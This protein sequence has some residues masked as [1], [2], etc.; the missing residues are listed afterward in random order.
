[1]RRSSLYFIVGVIL[2]FIATSGV[3][4]AQSFSSPSVFHDRGEMKWRVD[5]AMWLD[6]SGELKPIA[7]WPQGVYDSENILY[8]YFMILCESYTDSNGVV[9]PKFQNNNPSLGDLVLRGEPWGLYQTRRYDNPIVI[10]N[11]ANDGYDYEGA[12]DPDIPADIVTVLRLK[13]APGFW[14]TQTTYSFVNPNHDDYVI[15]HV[16]IEYTRN[17]DFRDDDPDIPPQDLL[18]VYFGISYHLQPAWSGTKEIIGHRWGEDAYDDWVDWEL[19]DPLIPSGLDADRPDMVLAYGWDGNE[20][21]VSSL[22]S[23]GGYFDDTGDPSFQHDQ[24]GQFLSYQY[25]GYT[26]LH[27]DESPD[28]PTNDE[29]QPHSMAIAG[30]Y[31][32]WGDNYSG[33]QGYDFIAAGEWQH[34]PDEEGN[35]HWV[36]G[37]HMIMGLGPYDFQEGDDIDIVWAVGVGGVAYDSTVI[38]GNDWLSWYRGEPGASFDDN[39]KKEFLSQGI[40]SLYLTLSR[41][42][43]AWDKL[44]NDERIP[45]PLPAPDLRATD[46]GGFIRLEWQDMREVADPVTGVPDLA[47]YRIYRKLGAALI[48]FREDEFGKGITYKFL[49]QV[50]PEVTSYLDTTTIRGESYHYYITA[51]DD[52]TQNTNGLFPGQQL[53]SSAYANRTQGGAVA[54]KPAGARNDSVRIVPN[55]Y[56]L[57]GKELNF[58]GDSNKLLFV[59]LPAYCTITIYNSTGDKIKAIPHTSGSGDESW[60]QLSDSNQRIVSGVYIAYISDCEN[61]DG[62]TLEDVFEKFVIVR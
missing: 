25:P 7:A 34:P 5:P 21:D 3:V 62:S 31:D 10:V 9:I 57:T 36:R 8:Q 40:D 28:N 47:G 13:T 26:L 53:E 44:R 50:G 43:W 54:F 32:I 20:E 51:L 56:I 37:D 30:Q 16:N 6:T 4:T 55:P 39:A 12:I 35:S 59:G 14:I 22:E 49:D 58:T 15:N 38:R 2:T 24:K 45:A 33:E 61:L 17:W 19:V 42:R 29:N 46:G 48:N 1:M 52:G 18:D 23:G 60:D 11:G 27:A 41:A